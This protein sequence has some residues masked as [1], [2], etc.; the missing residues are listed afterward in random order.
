MLFNSYLFL[1]GFLPLTLLMFFALARFFGPRIAIAG[2]VIASFTFYAWWDPVYL[3]LIGVSITANHFIGLRLSTQAHPKDKTSRRLLTLGVV[4]NLALL[5]YYKYANFLVANL[6]ALGMDVHLSAII[7]PL[8]ISFFTFTQIAYLVDAYRGEAREYNVL[9]YALFITYFPHLI[10]GPILH[11]KEIMPQFAN[12]QTFHFQ[13]ENMAIGLTILVIGLAKKVLLADP[14]GSYVAPAFTAAEQGGQLS[15]FTAWGGALAYTFQ[16]YFDFSGYA[17]MA[18]GTSRMF[19][20]RLP[21][22]FNSPYKATNII[23]FWRRWHMTLSRFLRDYL[24]IALGG[25]RKGSMRR[26]LHLYLTMLIGGIWHG[27]GWAFVIWGALHGVY[28][29]INHGWRELRGYNKAHPPASSGFTQL[30]C[31][32]LTFL[33]VVVSWVFFRA[34]TP[35]GAI[36]LLQAMAGFNGIEWPS[37]YTQLLHHIGTAQWGQV[38]SDILAAAVTDTLPT[39]ALLLLFLAAIALFLPNTQEIMADYQPAVDF[40]P[41]DLTAP[42]RLRW[43]PNP[44]QAFTVAVLLVLALSKMNQVSEF[45]Y[46]QF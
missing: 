41:D 27:A 25:N 24:Y 32:A 13:W 23:E 42:S 34:E 40:K 43:Q 10:A 14:I 17:D 16:L 46:F 31:W 4:F 11:H 12:P 9:H 8:G 1:F 33:A 26:Y 6:N 15:F 21:L 5:G 37:A 29:V 2:L 19:G 39:Q 28:L 18:I 45:L 38:I 36:N 7:L 3:W 22:N 35:A 44:W 30:A 20:I